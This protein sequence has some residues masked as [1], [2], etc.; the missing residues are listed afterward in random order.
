MGM[1][2][3]GRWGR[4]FDEEDVAGALDFRRQLAMHLGSHAG[5]AS[6]K[7]AAFFREEFLEEFDVFKVERFNVD[8][9]TT[10]RQGAERTAPGAHGFGCGRHI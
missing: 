8:V 6:R 3:V 10:L 2:S 1:L 4:L 9:D 7:D 5:D